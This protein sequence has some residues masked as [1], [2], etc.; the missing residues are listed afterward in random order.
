MA[1]R[2]RTSVIGSSGAI[3]AAA[4]AISILVI[5]A[6]FVV[7]LAA[8]Q[9]QGVDQRILTAESDKARQEVIVV[10]SGSTRRDTPIV[11]PARPESIESPTPTWWQRVTDEQSAW[12]SA[13][14]VQA[15]A[16]RPL[17]NGIAR[18]TPTPAARTRNEPPP[19]IDARAIIAAAR[20]AGGLRTAEN[21]IAPAVRATRTPV[22]GARATSSPRPGTAVAPESDPSTLA[23]RRA[24]LRAAA[25]APT[26]RTLRLPEWTFPTPT[27][28]ATRTVHPRAS[29]IATAIVTKLPTLRNGENKWGVGIYRDSGHLIEVAR[30][31]RP[32]VILLMDPSPQF[33]RA[34]REAAPD[35]FIVGRRYRREDDQP[36]DRPTERGEEMADY[37]AELAVPLKGIV[38]AWMSYN[39]VLGSSPSAD[40]AAYDAFQVA[41]ARRLQGSY[42]VSAVAANDGSGALEPDEYPRYFANAIRE[43]HFFGVHAYSPPATA[44]MRYDAEWNALRYRKIHDALERAGIKDKRMIITESGLGD[45]FR[46]GL[47]D[48]DTMAREFAWFSRELMKDAY[49]IGHAAFGLFDTRG[50]WPRFELTDT[51]VPRLTRALLDGA[52]T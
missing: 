25:V 48:D 10:A 3:T 51:Q 24:S 20:D 9:S 27:A 23:A 39:E 7:G 28:G 13:G 29:A 36:L 47:I 16:A 38:D 6:I 32:G 35:A 45:G 40:Y 12:L 14:G 52:S 22:A 2:R 31:T 8:T 26:Q 4:G 44:S 41:F 1:N 15:M 50:D 49:V 11:A 19:P 18:T 30:L 42:G 17:T 33:A 37:V 5:A 21:T 46:P 43:S 34:I